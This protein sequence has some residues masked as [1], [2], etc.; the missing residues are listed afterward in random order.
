MNTGFITLLGIVVALLVV[1]LL[2]RRMI[3][4]ILSN[5]GLSYYHSKN[6]PLALYFYNNSLKLAQVT[7]DLRGKATVA[8]NLGLLYASLGPQHNHLAI[9]RYKHSLTSYRALGD[10]AGEAITKSNMATA[11]I[12]GGKTEEAIE[13]MQQAVA[14]LGKIGH[15][16]YKG[17]NEKLAMFMALYGGPQQPGVDVEVAN[18]HIDLRKEQTIKQGVLEKIASARAANME[19]AVVAPPENLDD[20][21]NPLLQTEAVVQQRDIHTG[22]LFPIEIHILREK[23]RPTS[24]E[25]LFLFHVFLHRHFGQEV[26]KVLM[27]ALRNM[28]SFNIFTGNLTRSGQTVPG[29]LDEF[30][31]ANG[32]GRFLGHSGQFS[33]TSIYLDKTRSSFPADFR[34]EGYYDDE[35][36]DKLKAALQKVDREEDVGMVVVFMKN[37]HDRKQGLGA[38]A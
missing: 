31:R 33:V 24:D 23:T 10:I 2:L 27:E 6:Y 25:A 18:Y 19:H 37:T 13:L 3:G 12:T 38:T 22:Q 15:P 21:A 5:I 28:P 1:V 11:Y 14:T 34:Y 7:G 16:K 30:F 26:L 8:N 29:S 35:S 4:A 36:F 20:Q 9:D 32:G 17:H